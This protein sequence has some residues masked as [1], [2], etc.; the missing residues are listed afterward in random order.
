MAQNMKFP[1][2][3][4]EKIVAKV[5]SAAPALPKVGAMPKMTF[6]IA[7]IMTKFQKVNRPS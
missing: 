2:K 3:K 7:I 6:A 5:S 1:L 4:I